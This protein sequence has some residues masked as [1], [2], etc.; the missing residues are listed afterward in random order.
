MNMLKMIILPLIVASLITAVS[1][2]DPNVAG[3][4]GRRTLIYY[5]ATM[6]VA[7]ILGLTLVLSI[8]PGTSDK[9]GE[10]SGVYN[11]KQR[12]LDSMLDMLR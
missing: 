1:K 3:K 10:R 8:R 6:V 7:A 2:L 9:S 12:N 11:V 4:V 5:I